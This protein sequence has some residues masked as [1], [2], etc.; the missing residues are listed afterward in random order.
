MRQRFFSLR[1]F[2]VFVIELFEDVLSFYHAQELLVLDD[3]DGFQVFCDHDAGQVFH[4]GVRAGHDDFFGH[5]LFGR[6]GK[7]FLEALL[8]FLEVAVIDVGSQE[9][10][11]LGDTG[12]DFLVQEVCV[13]DDADDFLVVFDDRNGRD[14]VFYEHI[15]EVKD[16]RIFLRRNDIFFHDICCRFRHKINPFIINS[17][18]A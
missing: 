18:G 2:T 11:V 1:I 15:D 10:D 8:V 12:L 3:G 6:A 7:E 17:M 16:R 9:V 14:V 13:G 4:G 5:E